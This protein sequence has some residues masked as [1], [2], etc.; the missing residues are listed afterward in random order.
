MLFFRKKAEPP[1]RVGVDALQGLLDSL[2]DASMAGLASRADRLLSGIEARW[3][4]FRSVSMGF[5]GAGP[6]PDLEDLPRMS[7]EGITAMKS[8][9]ASAMVEAVRAGGE[10]NAA[11]T[12]YESY[13]ERLG[14]HERM[15]KQVL[16]VNYRFRPVMIAY[17]KQLDGFKSAFSSLER[18]IQELRKA[19]DSDAGRFNAY[20]RA[21]ASIQELLSGIEEEAELRRAAEEARRGGS[22]ADRADIAGL[23]ATLEGDAKRAREVDDRISDARLAVSRLLQP[24]DR[25]A[26]KYDH[27]SHSREKLRDYIRSMERISSDYGGFME[28][29]GKLESSVSEG[30]TDAKNPEGTLEDIAALR[31][32]DLKGLIDSIAIL[33]EERGAIEEEARAHRRQL[34]TGK[35]AAEAD[36]ARERSIERMDGEIRAVQAEEREAR[37]RIENAF[38]EGYGRRIEIVT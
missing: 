21:S 23:G 3:D 30:K 31:R 37:A 29:L 34:D 25:V 13:M 12:L 14:R 4:S 38:L 15:L 26:K 19:V 17:A 5:G 33:K 7:L 6:D 9:Y 32:S 11:R 24:L 18:G 36:A 27:E 28:M 35:S 20:S 8:D 10:V 22:R 2:F 16:Q 1:E